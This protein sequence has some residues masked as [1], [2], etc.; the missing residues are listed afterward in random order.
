MG[1]QYPNITGRTEKEQVEQMKR[2]LFQLTDQLNYVVSQF[3]KQ[4]QEIRKDS[5]A[6][7]SKNK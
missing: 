7:D 3:D 4:I 2:H 1:F 5:A 6:N